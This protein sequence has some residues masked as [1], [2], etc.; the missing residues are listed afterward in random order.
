MTA[1]LRK[2]KAELA[3]EIARLRREAARAERLQ[4]RLAACVARRRELEARCRREA[5]RHD[6]E[7]ALRDGA[8]EALRL[9]E[10]IIDRSP[11]VLFRRLAGDDPRLVYVSR[12]I[13][14]TGWSAEEFLEDRVRFKDIV[15]PEDS[16]RLTAEIRR[17]AE[18][19]REAYTQHYR[20]VTRGGEV[21]WVEDQTSV[22]RDA[23]G[24][25]LYY[26]GIVVDVTA[27]R[28]AEEALRKS[29]EKFRRIVESAGEGFVM[30]DQSL[31]ITD[32]NDAY[33]RMLG[34][35]RE[36]LIGKTTLDLASEGF[37]SFLLANRERLLTLEH[38][39]FEGTLVARD[40]R[41]VPVLV[42]ANTLRDDAGRPMGHAAFVVDLTEQKKALQLAGAVQRSLAPAEPP[43]IPGL[44]VAGRSDACQE[45]GGD[46]FDF[47]NG[48]GFPT[49]KLR[50]VVGDIS[51]HGVDAALLMTSARAIIRTR[52]A[53]PGTP[54]ELVAGMNRHF[55]RD[56]GESGHFM[57]LF[58]AEIDPVRQ[59]LCWVR[60]GHEP[61]LIY[62]P[63]EDRFEE[64]LGPG[65]ALGIDPECTFSETCRPWLAP[66]S[67]IALGTDGIRETRSPD[68]RLFGKS[69]F[70]RVLKRTAARPA[71]EIVQ[72]VFEELAAFG[73]GAP[74][75]DDVTLVVVKVG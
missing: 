26:Q 17:Y 29:E 34:Y 2:T 60:A 54:E 8:L 44:E 24:R 53:R 33:C 40:G 14:M 31:R 66:G 45:V 56:L 22:V 57:T 30:M 48:P 74:P 11:A 27:R 61:A 16:E 32:A 12:N 50:V 23:S 15:H 58:L 1:D 35:G 7:C 59:S 20:I 10:I 63:A 72:A 68:G 5:R 19:D 65:I 41:P 69:G 47:L 71:A 21:R 70:Q 64:L 13:R 18:E 42:H 28:R 6:R 52:A 39:R 55:T 3:G 37:R 46:Y 73:Q 51:G 25:K 62:S 38:R 36:E 9:A 67:I 75:E 43:R 49:D 4:R